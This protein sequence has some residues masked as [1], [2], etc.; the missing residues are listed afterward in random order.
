MR[1]ELE[2]LLSVVERVGDELHPDLPA[3]FLRGI[4]LIEEETGSDASEAISRIRALV[5]DA[6]KADEDAT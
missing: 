3:E 4:I 6:A 2:Q 5:K 1:T